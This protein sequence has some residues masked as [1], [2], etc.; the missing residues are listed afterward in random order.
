MKEKLSEKKTFWLAAG[1]LLGMAI[2]YY[3]PQEPAYA[4]TA[5]GTEKFSMCTVK[6]Q[7]AGVTGQSD[8]VFI[9][10]N[11][12]GRLLGAAHNAQTNAFTQT[13]AR[14]LAADFRVTD[15]AQYV[16]VSGQAQLQ[17]SGASRPANGC[18]YVGELNSGIVNMYGFQYTVGGRKIPTRELALIASFPWRNSVQ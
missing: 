3:C 14:S 13:Y 6:T 17:S 4:E 15:N 9:L 8:A 1:T 11:L 10:D 5:M 7:G 2:A 16:M 18:I 12:T